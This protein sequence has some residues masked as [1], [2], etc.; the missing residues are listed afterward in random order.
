MFK[1]IQRLFVFGCSFTKWQYPTWADILATSMPN[2]PYYNYGCAGAGNQFIFT[3]LQEADIQ[4]TFTANDLVI[5]Q[6]TNIRREDRF[7]EKTAMWLTPGN[8]YTQTIYSP[9]YVEQYVNDTHSAIR[10]YTCVYASLQM[11]KQKT[12][13]KFFQMTDIFEK[14]DQW[15][16]AITCESLDTIQKFYRPAVG[17]FLSESFYSILWNNNI[18]EK[19]EKTHEQVHPNYHDYHP[20]IKEHCVFLQAVFDIELSN[21][22]I[23]TVN[24]ADEFYRDKVKHHLSDDNYMTDFFTLYHEELEANVFSQFDNGLISLSNQVIAE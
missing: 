8:I 1:D 9:D 5:V 2:I 7:D 17:E 24:T 20:T 16:D 6:W 15:E 11:L 21:E 23:H 18:S 12:N 10:D 19:I 3:K 22:L 4:H 13:F 14:V